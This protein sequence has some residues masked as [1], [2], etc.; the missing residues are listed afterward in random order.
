[1]IRSMI[2]ALKL[3]KGLF[4]ACSSCTNTDLVPNFLVF[5]L[6]VRLDR[7]APHAPA[8][9]TQAASHWTVPHSSAFVGRLPFGSTCWPS[10]AIFTTQV[11]H[12]PSVRT[13]PVLVSPEYLLITLAGYTSDSW[14]IFSSHG[15]PLGGRDNRSFF[16]FPRE[17]Y[18]THKS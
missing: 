13:S 12:D 5:P 7:C 16:C 11:T 6:T 18:L 2:L 8:I 10:K 4:W 14:L 15:M 1:M 17:Q 9:L 3:L